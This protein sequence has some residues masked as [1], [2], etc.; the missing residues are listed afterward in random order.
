MLILASRSPRRKELLSLITEDFSVRPAEGEE[1]AD[2]RLSPDRYVMALSEAKAREIASAAP[3]ET[4]IGADTVVVF[5]NEILG[6]PKDTA[7]AVRM[8]AL[9]SGNTHSV[10]T[11][12]TVIAN[13]EIHSF[14]EETKVTFFPLSDEEIERYAESGEPLDKAGAYGIQGSGALLVQGIEGDYYN[15]MGLPAG[16]LYRFLKEFALI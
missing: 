3:N 16:R 12:V 5:G 4:V 15:V 11:G 6:K 1:I 13:D 2:P 14:A 7:D 10:F 8:L 9:L